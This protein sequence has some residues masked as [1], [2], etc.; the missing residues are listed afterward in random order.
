MPDPSAIHQ[1]VY[2]E[3]DLFDSNLDGTE[4]PLETLHYDLDGN[5]YLSDEERDEDADGLSNFDEDRGR[6]RPDWWTSCYSAGGALL[7]H[8]QRHGHRRSRHRR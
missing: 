1:G 8:L 7:H 2:I 4:T 6:V 3:V 5:D